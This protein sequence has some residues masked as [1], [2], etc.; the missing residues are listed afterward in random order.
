MQVACQLTG[1]IS[2]LINI[3]YFNQ[4]LPFSTF[5]QHNQHRRLH[6]VMLMG[7]AEREQVNLDSLQSRRT[8]SDEDNRGRQSRTRRCEC[9]KT[10]GANVRLFRISVSKAVGVHNLL[11]WV[12]WRWPER[13]VRSSSRD[14]HWDDETGRNPQH[15]TCFNSINPFHRTS[16]QPKSRHRQQVMVDRKRG[17]FECPS[18]HRTHI[19]HDGAASSVKTAVMTRTVAPTG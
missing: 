2:V 13:H 6:V 4:Y 7:R 1:N 9:T 18:L 8:A 10:G 19:Q 11:S 5:P 17:L 14:G 12:S 16:P 15:C 3:I